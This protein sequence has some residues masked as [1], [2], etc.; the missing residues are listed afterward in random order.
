MRGNLETLHCVTVSLQHILWFRTPEMSI[1][2]MILNHQKTFIKNQ[3]M[4]PLS[5]A[6]HKRIKLTEMHL[7]IPLCCTRGFD[8]YL[9]F[10][11]EQGD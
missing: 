8:N 11:T 9:H 2:Q 6:E 5:L 3:A 4:K 10:S 7:Q 1:I